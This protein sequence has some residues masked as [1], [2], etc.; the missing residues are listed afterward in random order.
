MFILLQ[1]A[2]RVFVHSTSNGA[3]KPINKPEAISLAAFLFQP[4]LNPNQPLG[5]FNLDVKLEDIL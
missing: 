5:M 4:I 2:C 3:Y 1:F